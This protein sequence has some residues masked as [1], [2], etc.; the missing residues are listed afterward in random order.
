VRDTPRPPV[1]KHSFGGHCREVTAYRD[2][3][4]FEFETR[5][6]H[7]QDTSSD[8]IL[9]RERIVAEEREVGGPAAGCH[10]P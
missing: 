6:E 2:V 7:L 8:I 10:A 5:A 9:R 4:R 1:R 3:V